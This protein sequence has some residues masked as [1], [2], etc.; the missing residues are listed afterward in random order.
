[1]KVGDRVTT[2]PISEPATDWTNPAARRWY[3]SGRIV[4]RSDAHGECFFVLHDKVGGI[5]MGSGWYEPAELR[6]EWVTACGICGQDPGSTE[7]FVLDMPCGHPW[8]KL[9]RLRPCM[10][11]DDCRDDDLMAR[12][13]ALAGKPAP[14]PTVVTGSKV[15]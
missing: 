9:H 8:I 10:A 11:H 13:C 6:P 14:P 3:V 12:L 7:T 2:Y 1:M 4:D 5:A 15:T